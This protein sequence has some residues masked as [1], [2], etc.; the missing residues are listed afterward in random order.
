MKKQ[1]KGKSMRTLFEMIFYDLI[2][3][4]N[5][6]PY[7]FF[8][9]ILISLAILT[10]TYILQLIIHEIGHLIFGLITGFHFSSF[11]VFNNV[12]IKN[13]R[14]FTIKK[15]SSKGSMGQCLMRPPK[16]TKDYKPYAL[17]N[18]GGIILNSISGC[19]FI[20][21]VFSNFNISSSIRIFTLF[22]GYYGVGFA[23]FNGLPLRVFKNNDGNNFMNFIKYKE[24][25]DSYYI[26]LELLGELQAGKTYGEL[27][28]NKIKVGNGQDLT[29]PLLGLH[30]IWEC[31]YFMD[32]YNWSKAKECLLS[33]ELY[34]ERLSKDIK[35]TVQLELLFLKIVMGECSLDI[36]ELYHNNIEL[37]ESNELD[38]D[39]LRVK[40]VYEICLINKK[41]KNASILNK[42]IVIKE[43]DRLFKD[44]LYSGKVMFN[45][46]ML[47]AVLDI[48]GCR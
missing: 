10:V 25:L 40:K 28:Y 32:N 3:Y 38:I 13:N 37:I 9:V 46:K 6:S 21:I 27:S 15:V 42:D 31:Y 12:L 45:K 7:R 26:L 29:L 2:Y 11:R 39:I 24:T 34:M 41:F 19:I 43:F 35:E 47:Q 16:N 14:R 23:I 36:D 44:Y 33:L 5:Q 8:Y 17:Y 1:P 20:Y 30:K 48:K 22:M 18:L 4:I